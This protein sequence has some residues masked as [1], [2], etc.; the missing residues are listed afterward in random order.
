MPETRQ[1][2]AGG[3]V[4]LK[5][6]AESDLASIV[7]FRSDPTIRENILADNVPETLAQQRAWFERLQWRHDQ[8]IFSIKDVNDETVLGVC[9]LYNI[10]PYHEHAEWGFYIGADKARNS[11]VAIETELLLLDHAFADR[12]LR[13]VWC[14]VLASNLHVLSLHGRFGFSTEGILREHAK[15]R[16]GFED[17]VLMGILAA[18]YEVARRRVSAVLGHFSAPR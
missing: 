2:K 5:P 18:E 14:R 7:E 8:E 16:R 9:G 15:T 1:T 6:V 4:S 11:P 13:R 3:F 12:R 17:V 10:A